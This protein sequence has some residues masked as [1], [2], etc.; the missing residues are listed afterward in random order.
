[1]LR[2]SQISLLFLQASALNLAQEEGSDI[3]QCTE[4][5]PAIWLPEES[6]GLVNPE[7]QGAC[8]SDDADNDF[9]NC[10]C[11]PPRLVKWDTDAEMMTDMSELG[12][13][14]LANRGL[15]NNDFHLVF[16]SREY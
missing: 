4:D 10:D 2:Y 11:V 14:R 5:D 9:Q 6:T 7:T 1:M 16:N 15:S 8:D 12:T 3:P 13:D